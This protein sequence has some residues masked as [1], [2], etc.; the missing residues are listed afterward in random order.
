MIQ[1]VFD[2]TQEMITLPTRVQIA[3]IAILF[4][5]KPVPKKI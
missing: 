4:T 5:A 2:K 1:R 3:N